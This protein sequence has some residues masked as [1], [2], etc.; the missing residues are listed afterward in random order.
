MS[1]VNVMQPQKDKYLKTV[2]QDTVQTKIYSLGGAVHHIIEF[3]TVGILNCDYLM[4]KELFAVS[5]LLYV[6]GEIT[7]SRGKTGLGCL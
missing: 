5:L 2:N 3:I 1:S 6:Q 4:F 7:A